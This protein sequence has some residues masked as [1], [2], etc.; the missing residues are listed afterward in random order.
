VKEKGFAMLD[1]QNLPPHYIRRAVSALLALLFIFAIAISGT[2]AWTSIA[3]VAVNQAMGE[4]SSA[5]ELLKLEKSAD[6]TVTGLPLPGA[7]FYLYTEDGVQVG[8]RL[9]T[10]EEG[11]IRVSLP[12]GNYYFI[13]TA[14]PANYTYDIDANGEE[15]RRHPFEVTGDQN[16]I[17]LVT[18]YNTRLLGELAIEKTVQGPGGLNAEFEFTITFS[19]EGTYTYTIDGGEKKELASGETLM[20]RHGQRALFNG[21]PAGVAY[22][23]I[24]TPAPEFAISSANHQG[25]VSEAGS[26]AR[27]VN[28]FSGN[29]TGSLAVS[30]IVTG[31]GADFKKEFAFTAVIGGVTHH[32]TLQHGAERRFD[33]IP[34]GTLYTVTETDNAESYTATVREYSGQIPA[35]GTEV[36]LPF[37]NVFGENPFEESGSLTVSKTA[38]GGEAD[39]GTEFDFVVIFEGEGAPPSPQAFTLKAG[40]AV[41]FNDIPFG[42]SYTITEAPSE[43]YA[44][45]IFTASGIIAGDHTAAVPFVNYQIPEGQDIE[46]TIIKIIEGKYPAEDNNLLFHFILEAEG[47]EPQ[48][49]TLAAGENISFLIP[50]GAVYTITEVNFPAYYSLVGVEN[51]FGTAVEGRA[52]TFTNRYN[53]PWSIEISGEKTWEYGEHIVALP[54]NI[55]LR[56]KNGNTVAA[57]AMVAPDENGK[58]LYTFSGIPKYDSD[59]NEINYTVEEIP[60]EGWNPSYDGYHIVNAYVPPPTE[61]TETT[62]P[63]E[64]T[65]T[66]RLAEP[67]EATRSIEPTET[68]RSIESMETTRSIEPTETTWPIEPTETALATTLFDNLAVPKTDDESNRMLWITFMAL[69]FA[70]LAV[71]ICL[72]KQ[73][74]YM[75]GDV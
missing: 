63:V 5:V 19:D 8:G 13:E 59:G 9:I 15:I 75:S 32:F 48:E 64:P 44:A 57:I 20:L 4:G 17:V 41:T 11:K 52:A 58:W 3:Q 7:E 54:A 27:F 51:G 65:E 34:V 74:K 31:E 73:K 6:G 38:V 1:I 56:L 2:F 16:E 66:T 33:N 50:A 22:T 39:P 14:P 72:K 61:P 42:V 62:K 53:G 46:L 30:K 70:G 45:A 60:V 67:T 47:Q 29:E 37:V 12:D 10:N 49:F 35:K 43:G 69:S 71:M 40:Q 26:T 55:A 18:A 36:R 25:V 28:T 23:V 68:T 24:E 21:I